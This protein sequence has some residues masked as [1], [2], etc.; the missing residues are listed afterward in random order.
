MPANLTIS[1]FDEFPL[2]TTLLDL[3]RRTEAYRKDTMPSQEDGMILLLR[4]LVEVKLNI[5]AY[6]QSYPQD[7]HSFLVDRSSELHDYLVSLP[8][9]Y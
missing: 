6:R 3:I 8:S 5:T 9:T 7:S 2:K 4:L 1:N